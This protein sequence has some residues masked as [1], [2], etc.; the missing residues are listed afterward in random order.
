MISI[1]MFTLRNIQ[2]LLRFSNLFY[3]HS[4]EKCRD[5]FDQEKIMIILTTL[6]HTYSQPIIIDTYMTIAERCQYGK[7]NHN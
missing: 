5:F 1:V 2:N 6:L 7:H 3:T 4:L